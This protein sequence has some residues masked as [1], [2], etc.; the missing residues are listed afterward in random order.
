ME[1]RQATQLLGAS[2]GQ[3]EPDAAV[4][5]TVVVA[6]DEPRVLGP[7]HEADGAVVPEQELLGDIPDGRL[8]RIRMPPDDQE[9]LM[10]G[11]RQPDDLGLL[12]AP[13]Q[14]AAQTR[15]E[16]QEAAVLVVSDSCCHIYIVA[17]YDCR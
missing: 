6:A 14:E 16:L 10:L 12:F 2:S 8:G 17:R 11:G 15:A 4:I 9:E 7:V 5:V 13:A 3:S 1:R